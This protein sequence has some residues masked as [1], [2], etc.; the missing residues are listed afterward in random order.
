MDSK[1]IIN[2][3]HKN[4]LRKATFRNLSL[5]NMSVIANGFS[6]L[7]S[8]RMGFGYGVIGAV[9]NKNEFYSLYDEDEIAEKTRVFLKQNKKYFSLLKKS[10]K[11]ANIEFKKIRSLLAKNSFSFIKKAVCVHYVNYMSCLGVFNCFWK[12]AG[13]EK[14]KELLNE[15]QILEI[16]GMRQRVAE[17]YPKINLMLENSIKNL[18][19]NKNQDVS[20]IT[21]MTVHELKNYSLKDNTLFLNKRYEGYVYF[22]VKKT[23]SVIIDKET[24]SAVKKEF[25][26]EIENNILQ[27]SQ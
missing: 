18:K 22:L 15:K 2:L 10:Q 19:R 9:G 8:K 12:Y 26:E 14:Q 24:I 7:L 16:A 3:F 17:L 25:I 6:S 5:L 27:F 20:C 21:S 1:S 4:K 23:E 13:N 11:E